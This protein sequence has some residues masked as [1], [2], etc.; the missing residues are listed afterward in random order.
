MSCYCDSCQLH[1]ISVLICITTVVQKLS[2]QQR[3]SPLTFRGI[4]MTESNLH[5]TYKICVV[6]SGQSHVNH[7]VKPRD[8]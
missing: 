4:S 6:C 8:S 7:S 5:L 2:F 3:L 1:S